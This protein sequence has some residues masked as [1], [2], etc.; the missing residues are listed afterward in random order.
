MSRAITKNFYKRT[1]W[2]GH[3]DNPCGTATIVDWNNER[4]I[5]TA[6]HVVH[7]R[8]NARKGWKHLSLRHNERWVRIY[9]QWEETEQDRDLDISVFR[10][11]WR[12]RTEEKNTEI[13]G[14]GGTLGTIGMIMGFPVIKKEEVSLIGEMEEWPVAMCAPI[15]AYST[16]GTT[17]R[18]GIAWGY[19]SPGFSGGPILLPNGSESEHPP[20]VITG[21]V[22]GGV[23]EAD[24]R[25][26]PKYTP[27]GLIEYVPGSQIAKLLDVATER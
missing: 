10:F 27:R 1:L 13:N 15:G 3:E 25:N 17:A 16:P 4:L 7:G 11:R 5:V 12:E 23:D 14:T 8:E 26:Q 6:H 22:I 20:W 24:E 2:L 21:I 9:D 18:R 19:G